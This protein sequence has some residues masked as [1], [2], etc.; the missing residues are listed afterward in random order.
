MKSSHSLLLALPS[1]PCLSVAKVSFLGK[2]LWLCF[3]GTALT[4]GAADDRTEAHDSLQTIVVQDSALHDSYAVREASTGTKTDTPLLET[5]VS[6][7]VVTQQMLKDEAV[8]TLD[9]ALSNVAG[10]RASNTGWEENIYLRGFPTS[11]YFRD[12]FRIDDPSGLGGLASL[13]NVDSIEV[14]KGPGA[15]L[16]GRVEPGG[17]VNLVT[18]QPTDNPLHSV[19]ASFGSW[20][21]RQVTL[22]LGGPL[23]ADRKVGY[24]FN[25]SYD[26]SNF[27]VDNV[28]DHKLFLAPTLSWKP[29]ADDQFGLEVLSVHDRATLYQQAV[30]PYDT[31]TMSFQFGPKSANPAPYRFNPN[32]LFVGAKWTHRFNSDWEL[33]QQVSHNRVDFSTPLN[34]SSAWGPLFQDSANNNAWTIGLGSAQLYGNTQSDGAVVDLVG[35]FVTGPAHHTLLVGGDA[36]RLSTYYNS[37][38]SNPAGPFVYVPL[39]SSQ[40]PSPGGIALDPAASYVTQGINK[41][42][43]LYVQD[44]VSLPHDIELLGGLRYQD[45]KTSGYVAMGTDMGG[46]GGA[47]ANAPTHESAL[48]PRAAILWKPAGNWS[49]YSSFAQNFGASNAANG[50]DWKGQALKPESANQIEVGSKAELVHDRVQLSLA[51]FNLTKTNVA[52]AD[53]AHPNPATGGFFMTSIGQI[54][55]KGVELSVQG[56]FTRDWEGSLAY[57]YDHAYVKVGTSV[58]AAGSDMPNFPKQMLRA[59]SSL[60]L[61]PLGLPSWKLGA[62]ANWEA[63]AAGIF[64]DPVTYA[65]TTAAIVSPSY[66]VFDA[67]ASYETAIGKDKL[68][69][70]LNVKNLANRSYYTDSFMYQ[71]PWGYVTWGEPR[72]FM[73]TA[74]L[75]F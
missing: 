48:T 64:V 56:R 60:K 23:D 29:D 30:V 11:T 74:Q 50:T 62:G 25:A 45:V 35:H 75:D 12:G 18:K 58:Y 19:S 73:T 71:A 31:S 9:D 43:G 54:E 67:M 69:L 52:A 16:Y 49:V 61:T 36:Y 33:H 32:T 1:R 42:S 14:L 44:Q 53:P 68:T 3:A 5:P 6:I 21:H 41:S 2:L 13:T 40:A 22:D 34:L 7:Q 70:Q 26:A 8:L 51:W 15:I 17:V 27:W 63:K 46:T 10:V 65:Q 39:F 28:A 47:V 24:R 59:F 55:S 38:Y 66:T 57:T 4:A 72:S 37:A 20:Q